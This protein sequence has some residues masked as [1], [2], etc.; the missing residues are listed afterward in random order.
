MNLFHRIGKQVVQGAKDELDKSPP[1]A[2]DDILSGISVGLEALLFFGLFLFGF[3]GKPN[4]NG[5]SSNSKTDQ[6]SVVINNYYDK[7]GN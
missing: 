5:Y 3:G 7:G 6:P 1:K 2:V 4:H